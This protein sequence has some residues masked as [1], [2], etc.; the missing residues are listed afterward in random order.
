MTADDVI[1]P[2]QI[3][4]KD[5]LLLE[6]INDLPGAERGG[7]I[8]TAFKG[9]VAGTFK[10][11]FVVMPVGQCSPPRTSEIEHIIVVLEGAFEFRVDSERHRLEVLDQIFVPVGVTWEYRNA[12]LGQSTFLSITGP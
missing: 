2:T 1:R 5:E 8:R 7:S 10:T 12:T 4:T 3:L 6:P 9:L 11:N